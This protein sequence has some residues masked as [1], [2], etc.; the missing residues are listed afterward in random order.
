MIH[1]GI[2]RTGARMWLLRPLDDILSSPA[3]V[4]VLRVLLR[5]GAHVL[6]QLGD[7]ERA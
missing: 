1:L 3:K 7:G 6:A 4:A 2:R 5:V